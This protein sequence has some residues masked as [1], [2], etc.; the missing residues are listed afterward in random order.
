MRAK[1]SQV[2][3][4]MVAGMVMSLGDLRAIYDLFF[5]DGVIVAKKDKHPKSMHP[6]INGVSNLKVICA[7]TSLKSKGYVR[8]TF[9]LRH[10]YYCI[11]N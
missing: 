1:R 4:R 11:T 8:E 6:D 2:E 7:M 10:S 5:Q 9:A 3:F